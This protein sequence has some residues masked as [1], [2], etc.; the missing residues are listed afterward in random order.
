M[1]VTCQGTLVSWFESSG[2]ESVESDP[3]CDQSVQQQKSYEIGG[4]YMGLAIETVR[5]LGLEIS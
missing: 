3:E 1:V 5:P 4:L 2:S